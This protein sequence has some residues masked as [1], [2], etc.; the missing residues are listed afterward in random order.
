MPARNTARRR[1]AP[2]RNATPKRK[3]PV[4][5]RRPGGPGGRPRDGWAVQDLTGFVLQLL[6][7][8]VYSR[9]A[10]AAE[11]GQ[12]MLDRGISSAP[13]PMPLGTLDDY[14]MRAKAIAKARRDRDQ[15]ELVDMAIARVAQLATAA[16]RAGDY[17]AAVRAENLRA[18]FEGTK[19]AIGVEVSAPGGG[20]VQVQTV[21]DA[22]AAFQRMV[23]K[24]AG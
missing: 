8:G 3:G 23:S 12:F 10:M 19:A 7:A 22:E 2:V 1:S 15:D 20:P 9:E 16:G 13:G 18:D 17:S 14:I 11:A 4:G 21:S 5:G 24:R 6:A